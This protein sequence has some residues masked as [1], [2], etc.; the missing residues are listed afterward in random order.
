MATCHFI[1][2]HPLC[3][4]VR[5]TA[6]PDFLQAHALSKQVNEHYLPKLISHAP[7]GYA[8][9]DEVDR[10]N[11]FNNVD[12]FGI[13]WYTGARADFNE[14]KSSR[15][16]MYKHAQPPTNDYNF[17]SVC[18]NTST[19]TAF[20]HIR[21]ATATPVTE[22]NNHPFVFGRHAIMHNGV[23]SNFTDIKREM[24]QMIGKDAFETIHGGT[25]SEHLAAL[26]MTCLTNGGGRETWEQQYPVKEM[27]A[28]LTTAIK[29]VIRLQQ[30]V[31][32]IQNA[33]ANSL[34]VACTDGEQMIGFRVRNHKTEQPPSLYWS[35]TAGVTLNRK[36]PDHPNGADN[37]NAYKQPE[38][39]GTHMI[40]AS[41]PTTYKE[42]EWNLIPKNHCCMVGTDGLHQIEQ[43]ELGAE[44][45]AQAKTTQHG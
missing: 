1:A 20:G 21:S 40:I 25:D 43:V 7:D 24:L 19:T 23:I 41:E 15:P 5:T 8:T 18:A 32:G 33:E 13:V 45:M 38:E 36:Y 16:A 29:M 26:Y 30:Q 39:H 37:P 42:D 2:N 3:C 11:K 28:A 34:N 44:Y 31:L 17:R 6:V 4:A 9:E 27:M 14:A 35:N 10:R 22:T 12:G